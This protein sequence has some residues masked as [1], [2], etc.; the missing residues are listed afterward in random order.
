MRVGQASDHCEERTRDVNA[1]PDRATS[2]LLGV[3][4]EKV[5]GKNGCIA[6]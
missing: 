1:S 4:R 5:S 2:G 3:A 6:D